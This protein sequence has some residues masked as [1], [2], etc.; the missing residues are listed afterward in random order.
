[1]KHIKQERY[2]LHMLASG[3]AR[4]VKSLLR[5]ASQ[6]QIN[7]ISEIASNI[8]SGVIKLSGKDKT[9]LQ[10][11]AKVIRAVGRKENKLSTR[12]SS[13]Y[14]HWQAVVVLLKIAL[15]TLNKIWL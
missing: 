10:P 14:K 1:M 8:L 2:Y 9:D 11:Y 12:R 6:D 15:K 4:Q 3:D 7:I 13:I 5:L